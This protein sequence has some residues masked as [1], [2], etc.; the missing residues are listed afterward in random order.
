MKSSTE[1]AE[2]CLICGEYI[3]TKYDH[4]PEC[5]PEAFVWC[6]ECNGSGTIDHPPISFNDDCPLCEGTGILGEESVMPEYALIYTDNDER[7]KQ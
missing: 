4:C 3:P 1:S 6:H 2:P 7:R 5:E